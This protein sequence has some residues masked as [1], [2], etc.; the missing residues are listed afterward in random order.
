MK[1][2]CGVPQGSI[3]GPLLFL[4]YFND[5]EKCLK[6]AHCLNFADD[7]VVY[8]EGKNKESIEYQLNE[9]LKLI[10]TYFQINQL[11][12]NLNKGKTETMLFGTSKKLSSYGKKLFLL[13]D[14]TE[15]QATETYKYLGATLDSSLSLSTNFDKNLQAFSSQITYVIF[16]SKLPRW[17]VE[18]KDLQRNDPSV[19]NIQ[20]YGKLKFEPNTKKQ[21]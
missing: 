2:T 11:V 1:I 9:D 19:H 12:I 16:S 8:V 4:I 13:F 17:I 15:I 7:T 18:K 3:L 6:Y 10:S 14:D 21:A 5:F 20:L